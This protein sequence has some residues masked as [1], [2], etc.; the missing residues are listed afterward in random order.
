MKRRDSSRQRG[1]VVSFAI[2][3]QAFAQPQADP[4]FLDGGRMARDRPRRQGDLLYRKVDSV[5]GETALAQFVAEELD[6]DL[7]NQMVMGD[8]ELCPDQIGTFGSLTSS[9]PARSA[10]GRRRGAPR[11]D[12]A[13]LLSGSG[14]VENLKTADGAVM[15]SDG[16]RIA[17]ASWSKASACSERFRNRRSSDAGGVQG[18]GNPRSAWSCRPRSSHAHLHPERARPGSSM[19]ASSGRRCMARAGVHRRFG[20]EEAAGHPQVV[21]KG[22]FLAWWPTAKSRRSAR[23]SAQGRVGRGA[24]WPQRRRCR[25]CS[26]APRPRRRWSTPRRRG[27]RISESKKTHAAQYYV[28]TSCTLDR[29]SCAIADVKG[30][31]ATLWSPTQTSFLTRDSVAAILG[32]PA[33]R[34]RLILGRGSGCYGQNRLGRRTGDAGAAIAADRAAGARAWMRR[35]E[36]CC[37]PK[38]PP[39]VMG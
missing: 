7:K 32:M 5:R 23:R 37:E 6:V 1:R 39:M 14:S 15:T 17:S 34:V 4:R 30:D 28:L 25:R 10:P 26:S 29:P 22:N 11:M 18:V 20:P 3:L 35:D 31:R 12:G 2:P 16:K 21:R 19:G 13:S 38:G 24:V 36:H 9:W 8:T 27:Q 33:S